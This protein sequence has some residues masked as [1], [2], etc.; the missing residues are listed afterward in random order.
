MRNTLASPRFRRRAYWTGGTLGVAGLVVGVMVAY[1]NSR[2]RPE[3]FSSAAPQVQ[4]SD[5]PVPATRER[6]V[7]VLDA[8]LRFVSTAVRRDHVEASWTLVDPSLKQGFTR[9]EWA[10]GNIPVVPYPARALAGW[11]LDWSYTDDVGLDVALLPRKGAKVHAKTFLVELKRDAHGRWLVASW[12][13]KGVSVESDL[14][15][16]AAGQKPLPPPQ[17]LGGK[18][19]L[20][21][22][23]GLAGLFV[24]P[25]SL[26]AGRSWFRSMRAERAYRRNVGADSH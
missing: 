10:K 15:D 18:W 23:L 24:I 17:S 14:A 12:V 6:R 13:P 25:L 3:V 19:L 16:A 11:K 4:V 5:T 7:Q 22:L 26:M 21:P 1:P 8:T 2:K 9:R 20:F